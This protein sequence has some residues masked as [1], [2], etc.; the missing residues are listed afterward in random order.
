[1]KNIVKIREQLKMQEI[2]R[3]EVLGESIRIF[4]WLIEMKYKIKLNSVCLI[5]KYSHLFSMVNWK[6]QYFKLSFYNYIADVL[7]IFKIYVYAQLLQSCPTL[8]N[9]NGP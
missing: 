9:S 8:C 2:L 1:M 6:I 5:F 3:D 7:A 4:I